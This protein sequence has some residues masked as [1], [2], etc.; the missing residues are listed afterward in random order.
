MACY[1]SGGSGFFP[2]SWYAY[3]NTVWTGIVTGIEQAFTTCVNQTGIVA[4]NV[5]AVATSGNRLT[6]VHR[7]LLRSRKHRQCGILQ[8]P[9]L[10]DQ[11]WWRELMERLRDELLDA[12]RLAGG[13]S[14]WGCGSD[15]RG[16]VARRRRRQRRHLY[17]DAEHDHRMATDWMSV[18]LCRQCGRKVRGRSFDGNKARHMTPGG[19]MN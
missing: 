2:G 1:N 19:N 12:R 17:L 16:L 14:R 5:I 4:N 13:N 10:P 15:P 18:W 6:K 3:N 9:L 8:Q 7:Q 11:R